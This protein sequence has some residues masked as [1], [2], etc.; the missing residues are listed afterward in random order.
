MCLTAAYLRGVNNAAQSTK[1]GPKSLSSE[2]GKK[3]TLLG[4][5]TLKKRKS[6]ALALVDNGENTGLRVKDFL[7]SL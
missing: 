7:L 3:P 2:E 4:L 1:N 5:L 6:G